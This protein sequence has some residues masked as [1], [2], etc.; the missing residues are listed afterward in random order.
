MDLQRARSLIVAGLVS[1]DFL[2]SCFLGLV[3]AVV[4]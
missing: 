2:R 1:E 3:L 4:A